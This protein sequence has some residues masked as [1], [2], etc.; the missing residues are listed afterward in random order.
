MTI[1][2]DRFGDVLEITLTLSVVI[3]LLL[4]LRPLPTDA[5]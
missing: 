5:L 4:A 2:L 1:L 3:A